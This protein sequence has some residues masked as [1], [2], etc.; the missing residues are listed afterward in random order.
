MMEI[1]KDVALTYFLAFLFS[2]DEGKKDIY[3]CFLIPVSTTLFCTL[4]VNSTKCYCQLAC[5]L[6]CYTQT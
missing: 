4:S 5:S 6:V 2:H 1:D 3:L